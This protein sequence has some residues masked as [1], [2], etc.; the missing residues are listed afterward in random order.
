MDR[1]YAGT[2]DLQLMEDSLARS[3]SSTSLRVGDLSWMSRDH[4]H[5][6]LSLDI[7]LWQDASSELIAWAFFR[8]YGEFNVFVVPDSGHAEDASLCDD[9]LA[10]IDHCAES[11]VAAGDPPVTLN[12]YAI[13]PTRS[14][15]DRSLAT[16][17][18]RAG[19]AVDDASSTSGFVV[20]S[21]DQLPS[22]TLPDGYHFDWV[23]T[24]D[25][26]RGRVEA[27]RAAFA[28][29]DLSVRRYERLQRTWAYRS[30]LD[31]LV[32]T[33]AGEVVS[34]CT[35]WYDAHNAS[36]L[37]EPVGTHPDH[38]RHGLARAVC[39]DA[40]HALLAT[41]AHTAQVG[42]GSAAGFATYTSAGFHQTNDELAYAKPW[43]SL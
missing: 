31:R 11:A 26:L 25:L 16:A 17:L 22:A 38:Q 19:Y 12:T 21:L 1:A 8:H 35:A 24:P 6:E 14:V 4:T 9:V 27:H 2:A 20:R 10:F 3:Y 43:R 29:S 18:E 36:G 30:T 15:V 42:Y 13:D 40:C 23:S 7:H 28:P 34:F 37:L 5:R 33:D 41:G 39:L 32:V